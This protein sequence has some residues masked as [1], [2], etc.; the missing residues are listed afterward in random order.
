M[1]KQTDDL[2]EEELE[3]LEQHLEELENLDSKDNL[4]YGSPEPEKKENMFKFFKEI[5]NLPESWKVGNLREEEIGKSKLGVRSYLELEK[6]S[7]AEGLDLVATYFRD[8][9]K[10]V[11]E[12]TMGRK[13]FMS[14]L[15]VTNIRKDHKV[16]EPTAQKKG[17][18]GGKTDDRQST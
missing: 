4:N 17:W 9:A 16:K 8:Q 2:N 15:F 5:I 1:K 13:G 3:Q 12:P 18:F 11:A 10:I 6:Y 14:Q 7:T